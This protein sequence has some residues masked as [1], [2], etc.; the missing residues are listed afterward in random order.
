MKVKLVC[1]TT[2]VIALMGAFSALGSYTVVA[3]QEVKSQWTGVYTVD[4]ARRGEMLY[5]DK[6]GS[7]HG[8]E[9][10]GS[11]MAPGLIDEAFAT[12][13]DDQTLT[14]LFERIRT[15]MP[16]ND[17]GSLS[18]QQTADILAFVLQKGKYPA[19]TQELPSDI[20]V[21]KTYKFLAK[22]PGA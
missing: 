16:Q 6:C 5:S 1:G 11:E 14:D 18:V 4:Q 9:V 2:L 8:A 7:C 12:K 3:A 13:W 21:L 22:K 10:T 15:T 20:L 19:G 17:P